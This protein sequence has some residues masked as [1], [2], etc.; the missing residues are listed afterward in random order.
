MFFDIVETTMKRKD[1]VIVAVDRISQ[2][3][4]ALIRIDFENDAQAD[5]NTAAAQAMLLE[6]E[7][8]LRGGRK[9]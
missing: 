8:I 7:V 1:T 4:S 9:L 2:A 6:A 5:H 3:L